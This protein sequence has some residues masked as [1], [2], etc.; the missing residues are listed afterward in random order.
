M[1]HKPHPPWLWLPAARWAWHGHRCPRPQSLSAAI[2]S[3]L[4][5]YLLH[6]IFRCPVPAAS[7]LVHTCL[8]GENIG[9]YFLEAVCSF[10]FGNLLAYM[11][12]ERIKCIFPKSEFRALHSQ[13]S[14]CQYSIFYSVFWAVINNTVTGL[15]Q[16]LRFS[17]FLIWGK[18]KLESCWTV[19]VSSEM[20]KP[21]VA[22]FLVFLGTPGSYNTYSNVN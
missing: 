10:I 21:R 11:K 3:P 15:A 19:G 8:L 18:L 22:H 13:T 5:V 1:K 6:S 20:L 7:V 17:C 14:S 9:I 16:N 2:I 12:G 4:Y